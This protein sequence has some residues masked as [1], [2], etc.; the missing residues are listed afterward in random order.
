MFTNNTFFLHYGCQSLQQTHATY[1]AKHLK[2]A[3]ESYGNEKYYF[4]VHKQWE[5]FEK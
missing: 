2:G 3:T 4:W 1:K 5:N